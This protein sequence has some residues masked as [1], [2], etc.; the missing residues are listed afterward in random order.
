MAT[1]PAIRRVGNGSI[2]IGYYARRA[3]ALRS[4]FMR[5][6]LRN[7]VRRM[8]RYWQ[9]HMAEAEL[10]ALD[11]RALHDI[12]IS[13]SDIPAIAS[14]FYFRDE[15]RRQRGRSVSAPMEEQARWPTTAFDAHQRR[16]GKATM[17]SLDTQR[18][19]QFAESWI[20]AWNR[21]DLD[22]V[23]AHYSDDFEFSSPLISQFAGEASGRL[24]GKAAMLAYWQTGL[25]SLPDLRFELVDV[26]A[27]V[28]GL[29]ILYRGHRG[30]SAEVFEFD[31]N[32]QAR[33][34]QALYAG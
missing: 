10:D 3:H 6:W 7:L 19:R 31:A 16:K 32:G 25:S 18:P 14:K 9:R 33:R 27:G 1:Q 34:G 24:R 11:D 15:S 8:V 13:R 23:L 2:D 30:L 17:S 22:A 4:R 5:A 29:L 28:D 21:H 26:L 20:G 12:G